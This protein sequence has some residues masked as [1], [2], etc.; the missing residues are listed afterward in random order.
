[1]TTYQNASPARTLTALAFTL[2]AGSVLM[3]G[4]LSPA[5]VQAAQSATTVSVA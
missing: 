3:F 5:H 4:A 1:M 2:I